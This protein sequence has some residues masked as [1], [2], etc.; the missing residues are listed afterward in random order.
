METTKLNPLSKA[1]N[2]SFE[3]IQKTIDEDKRII[4]GFATTEDVD[5]ED[6]V[7]SLKAVEK[8]LVLY[9]KNPTVRADHKAPPIGTTLKA[10]AMQK[11][12]HKGLFVQVQIGKNTRACDEAWALIKQGL[13]K[14]FSIGGI[15]KAIKSVY[16]KAA[17]KTIQQINEIMISEISITDAPANQACMFT[18]LGK[19][20]DLKSLEDGNLTD[21]KNES[22]SEFS[23]NVEAFSKRIEGVEAK[24]ETMSK[25]ITEIKTILTKQAED[26]ESDEEKKKKKEDEEKAEKSA[27]IVL[28]K[29]METLGFTVLKDPLRT[30]NN[31]G[32]PP[33][34]PSNEPATPLTISKM[35]QKKYQTA[36]ATAPPEGGG[37]T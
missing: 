1:F 35:L 15:V 4:E 21:T 27:L 16:S 36:P 34:D 5:R 8:A 2:Y 13:Y 17:G 6:Q 31:E 32:E 23:K 12:G 26:S 9:Q 10:Q 14:A 3:I 37:I 30:A 19:S 25:D 28:K 11:N 33:K 29:Q 7:V 24:T 22:D 18:V 20:V